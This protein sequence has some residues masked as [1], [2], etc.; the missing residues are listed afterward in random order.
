M[1]SRFSAEPGEVGRSGRTYPGA[2]FSRRRSGHQV[3]GAPSL[4]VQRRDQPRLA[5]AQPG[6][7]ADELDAVAP[8]QLERAVRPAI[9]GLTR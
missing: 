2:V 7:V 5:T 6:Y 4:T 3:M 8:M 9:V 1:G